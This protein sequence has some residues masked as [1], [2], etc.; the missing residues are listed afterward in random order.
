MK[1]IKI[2][3]LKDGTQKVEVLNAVGTECQEF[4]KE[5]EKR[6]G[7]TIGERTLKPEFYETVSECETELEVER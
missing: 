7:V 2:T 5:L 1:K 4:T 3:L 6:L